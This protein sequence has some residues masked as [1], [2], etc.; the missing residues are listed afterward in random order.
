[1]QFLLNCQHYA[2]KIFSLAKNY[3]VQDYWIH[4][5]KK[6]PAIITEPKQIMRHYCLKL[7]IKMYI[8]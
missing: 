3:L 1:M 5:A 2:E 7:F 4:K 6:L 8:R